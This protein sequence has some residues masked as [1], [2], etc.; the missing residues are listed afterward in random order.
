MAPCGNPDPGPFGARSGRSASEGPA[1]TPRAGLRNFDKSLF[2]L[3]A[4]RHAEIRIRG[5]LEPDPADLPRKALHGPPARASAI[6]TSRCSCYVHGAM[7]KSGSEAVWSPIRPICLGRPCMDPPRG[8]PQ[9]RQVVVPVMCMAPCG[10]PDPGPFGARS[11]R[12]ASERAAWTPRAGL[13][14][15]DKSLFLLCAWGHARSRVG[16]GISLACGGRM[17]RPRAAQSGLQRLSA[18][19]GGRLA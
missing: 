1:W 16:S 5:R 2:L 11:G 12:S 9:F 7:R 3:C 6:S 15:F 10:N 18:W 4:W 14:N 13:R 8:P 19:G 17:F